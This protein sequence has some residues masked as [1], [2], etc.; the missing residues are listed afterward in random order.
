MMLMGDEYGHTRHGNNNPYVQDNEINW[1][2]WDELKKKEKMFRFISSL[3]AFR[4][5]LKG[6]VT[7]KAHDRFVQLQIGTQVFAAFNAHY[8]SVELS[9]PKARKVVLTTEDW[10]FHE[11]GEILEKVTLAPY[12]SLLLYSDF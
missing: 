7:T 4:K 12:S 1:F 9:L 10:E 3:I 11:R 2:L 6:S 5:K 8:Q